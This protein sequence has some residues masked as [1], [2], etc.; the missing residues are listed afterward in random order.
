M[1][2]MRPD[3]DDVA[4][5]KIKSAA[6]RRVYDLL[7]RK[8]PS[9]VLVVH[10]LAL[11]KRLRPGRVIDGEADFVVFDPSRGMI[12]IE[13][14][15]GG[16]SHDPNEGWLS[17]D[18]NDQVHHISDP[19]WQAS[20]NKHELTRFIGEARE[21]KFGSVPAGHAV[22]FPDTNPRHINL[23]NAQRDIVGG[24]DECESIE[25]WIDRVCAFWSLNGTPTLARAS[26]ADF[27]RLIYPK[28]VIPELLSARFREQEDKRIELTER[29]A[30]ILQA[31]RYHRRLVISGGAGTGKTLLGSQRA[32]EL[33]RS[34]MRTLYLCY[35]RPLADSLAALSQLS[36]N[37]YVFGFHSLC[38]HFVRMANRA[39]NR[40]V[41]D[42]A[43]ENF[44]GENPYDVQWPFALTLAA[45]ALPN[46][47][48]DAIIVDEAQDFG[49]DY[50]LA[51]EM[52]LRTSESQ[53]LLF[54]DANQAI[55]RRCKNFPIKDPPFVLTRNC[56][57]TRAI[58]DAAYRYYSG[59]PTDATDIKGDP[60]RLVTAPNGQEQARAILALV[61]EL[62]TA[63]VKPTD[64]VFSWSP[65]R[66]I[67]CWTSSARPQ[68]A[69]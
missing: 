36:E 39:T 49:D 69:R 67:R 55:Y 23:P 46:E 48:F 25:S 6:E 66:R 65:L 14:K 30:T 38:E 43:C 60:I 19:F 57:N 12:V 27:E 5:A 11:L 53:L 62:G 59:D 2:R 56:R 21:W 3:L 22:L 17:T 9:R 20:T 34:G 40:R 44:P 1:A 33:A 63:G 50:W 15:G 32:F 4:L 31:A 47:R 16:I 37:L 61:K 42:E 28:I 54:F 7:R 68:K 51:V 35:N 45:D 41:F 29:Q 8:L 13:V 10:S 24:F 26:A 18:R 64:I 52:L 58:H